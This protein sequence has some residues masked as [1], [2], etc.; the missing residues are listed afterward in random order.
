MTG[1]LRHTQLLLVEIGSCKL[2]SWAGLNCDLPDF[3]LPSSE[4]YRDELSHL[5]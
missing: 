2:L 1:M 3:C 5:A 4:D